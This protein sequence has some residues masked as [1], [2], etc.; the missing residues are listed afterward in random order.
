VKEQRSA[1]TLGEPRRFALPRF[2]ANLKIS[3]LDT[4][5]LNGDLTASL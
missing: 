3:A 5:D 2:L 4:G 1:V